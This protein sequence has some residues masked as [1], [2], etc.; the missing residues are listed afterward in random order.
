[1]MRSSFHSKR[2]LP[3]EYILQLA[4][5]GAVFFAGTAAF[6]ASMLVSQALPHMAPHIDHAVFGVLASTSIILLVLLSLKHLD[7]RSLPRLYIHND[8]KAF[9]SGVFLY[10]IPSGI[11]LTLAISFGFASISISESGQYLWLSIASV[12]LLVFLSEALPEELLFRGY[13]QSKLAEMAQNS[14]ITIGAQAL[15]FTAFAFLIGA[16]DSQ[17]DASFLITFAIILGMC[18]MFFQN[19]WASIGFHLACMTMQQSFGANWGIFAVENA[20]VVQTYIL[21]MIPLTVAAALLSTKL[22]NEHR[23]IS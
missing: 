12:A 5:L 21:G 7:Q 13:I 23:A 9:F 17:L 14:W 8:V 4:K 19:L 3:K 10:I 15:M 6:Y 11:A 18:R 22:L 20:D 1:M 16:V 2:K